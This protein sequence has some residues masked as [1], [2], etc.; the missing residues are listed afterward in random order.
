MR[1]F[2]ERCKRPLDTL[3]NVRGWLHLG[4]MSRPTIDSI[5]QTAA[6]RLRD[7]ANS[8]GELA[9]EYTRAFAEAV[10]EEVIRYYSVEEAR[11]Y[12]DRVGLTPKSVEACKNKAREGE[13]PFVKKGQR[14]PLG[15]G[16]YMLNGVRFGEPT[17][18]ITTKIFSGVDRKLPS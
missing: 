8:Y 2:G 6:L 4:S 17:G 16:T 11:Q 12:L 13:R 5:V 7:K 3:D 9:P 18:D 15:D 10:T 14:I 1:H